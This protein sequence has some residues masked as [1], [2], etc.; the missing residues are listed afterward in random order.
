MP[1][2]LEVQPGRPVDAPSRGAPHGRE[3][4]E[5]QVQLRGL[6]LWRGLGGGLGRIPLWRRRQELQK[7]DFLLG[8]RHIRLVDGPELVVTCER[9]HQGMQGQCEKNSKKASVFDELHELRMALP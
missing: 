9:K 5:W 7:D 4:L 8:F 2:V 1:L 6:V 3:A